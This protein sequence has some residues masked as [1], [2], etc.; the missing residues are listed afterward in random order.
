[1]ELL[2][3]G[4]YEV[5]FSDEDGQTYAEFALRRDQIIP[6]HNQGKMLKLATHPA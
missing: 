3:D 2:G 1:M 4:I 6:L 5:E